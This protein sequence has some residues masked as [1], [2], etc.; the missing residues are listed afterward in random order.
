MDKNEHK[1]KDKAKRISPVRYSLRTTIHKRQAKEVT[2][3]RNKTIT[4]RAKENTVMC[5][6]QNKRSNW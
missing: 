3:K 2:E 1:E 6:G 5:G 4:K